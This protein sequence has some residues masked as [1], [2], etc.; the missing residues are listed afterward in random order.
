MRIAEM[1]RYGAASGAEHTTCHAERSRQLWTR[2]RSHS[3]TSM[4]RRLPSRSGPPPNSPYL[5]LRI[6]TRHFEP[7]QFLF[8]LMKG[9]VADLIAVTHFVNGLAGGL[10]GTPT[11]F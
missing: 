8:D 3:S 11:D 7:V 6:N 9:V 2:Y 1:S 4:N 10:E 5:R